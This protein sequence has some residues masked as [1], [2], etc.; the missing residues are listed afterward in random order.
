MKV[1]STGDKRWRRRQSDRDNNSRHTNTHTGGSDYR[2]QW[3][4]FVYGGLVNANIISDNANNTTETLP[5]GLA[6]LRLVIRDYH[7]VA[8]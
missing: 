7:E 2:R 6:V 1:N 4:M 5:L 8:E 3:A